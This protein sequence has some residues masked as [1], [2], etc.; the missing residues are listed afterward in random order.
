MILF[1]NIGFLKFCIG[2][3]ME[4]NSFTKYGSTLSI[5]NHAIKLN[6]DAFFFVALKTKTKH[7]S[8]FWQ[9]LCFLFAMC[10]WNIM[11]KGHYLTF[12][13]IFLLF[14]LQISKE[15]RP[16]FSHFARPIDITSSAQLYFRLL[17]A[18]TLA[19][20]FSCVYA[21][22]QNSTDYV[23]FVPGIA[24]EFGEEIGGEQKKET[25]A[26]V[27]SHTEFTEVVLDCWIKNAEDF[28]CASS[29]PEG[30]KFFDFDS[31][32]AIKAFNA[33][34]NAVQKLFPPR[35]VAE[36][37][38]NM[39]GV[40]I[41]SGT[42]DT[43]GSKMIAAIN[44]IGK[45]IALCDPWLRKSDWFTAEEVNADAQQSFITGG[46][47]YRDDNIPIRHISIMDQFTVPQD[48]C[49]ESYF[50]INPA[51]LQETIDL[52]NFFKKNEEEGVPSSEWKRWCMDRKEAAEKLQKEIKE[53]ERNG[54]YTMAELIQFLVKHNELV[55]HILCCNE[56]YTSSSQMTPDAGGPAF[57]G[58]CKSDPHQIP[59][60][61]P[62]ISSKTQD[63]GFAKQVLQ[64]VSEVSTDNPV[65]LGHL[66]SEEYTTYVLYE[67]A[68]PMKSAD[69][70]YSF[71]G[72][73]QFVRDGDHMISL[74]DFRKLSKP[75]G[76][77]KGEEWEEVIANRRD[78]IRTADVVPDSVKFVR[79]LH[80]EAIS[81]SR[82]SIHLVQ[83]PT[84]VL[85]TRNSK[86]TSKTS[87][88]DAATPSTSGTSVVA[89]TSDETFK[90]PRTPR[91]IGVS[92]SGMTDVKFSF[93]TR[94]KSPSNVY[95][96]DIG[97]M[98]EAEKAKKTESAKKKN[99]PATGRK[100]NLSRQAEKS[101]KKT[102][103]QKTEECRE[104]E[105]GRFK[106]PRAS[107]MAR[108]RLP[109]VDPNSEK[110]RSKK[111]VPED[112]KSVENR[113]EK[114]M[115]EE[116]NS[117]DTRESENVS[118][119][120]TKEEDMSVETNPEGDMPEQDVP[121][122]DP[123]IL[124]GS[125][126]DNKL[127]MPKEDK[128]KVWNTLLD[129]KE[130][131]PYFYYPVGD[132][133]AMNIATRTPLAV[134]CGRSK[135]RPDK[136]L[137]WDKR[138]HDEKEK[139]RAEKGITRQEDHG[140]QEVLR[141]DDHDKIPRLA[142]VKDGRLKR[143][144]FCLQQAVDNTAGAWHAKMIRRELTNER[145][146]EEYGKAASLIP[147]PLQIQRIRRSFR[148]HFTY[149]PNFPQDLV[150][151]HHRLASQFSLGGTW[152]DH[153]IYLRDYCRAQ[154]KCKATEGQNPVRKPDT[155]SKPC[156]G[157]WNLI[158]DCPPKP[159]KAVAQGV[160][161]CVPPKN[162]IV[163]TKPAWWVRAN[164]KFLEPTDG[165]KIMDMEDGSWIIRATQISAQQKL[166][167]SDQQVK[168]LEAIFK[169]STEDIKSKI[170]SWKDDLEKIMT[171]DYDAYGRW[172]KMSKL[173]WL[174][175]NRDS[176]LQR[177]KTY[178]DVLGDTKGVMD[179]ENEPDGFLF[180]TTLLPSQ[181]Q[182]K[183]TEED[184]V[185]GALLTGK[186]L[187]PNVFQDCQL[188]ASTLVDVAPQKLNKGPAKE[189]FPHGTT[190][191][192]T[193]APGFLRAA[194][195]QHKTI[196]KDNT[197]FLDLTPV[198]LVLGTNYP[199]CG[200]LGVRHKHRP[201]DEQIKMDRDF[202]LKF[203]DHLGI[204]HPQDFEHFRKTPAINE[205]GK[206][207]MTDSTKKKSNTDDEPNAGP[208]DSRSAPGGPGSGHDSGS[209]SGTCQSTQH[210]GTTEPG[211]SDSGSGPWGSGSG[212]SQN[213][214]QGDTTESDKHGRRPE[215]S[216]QSED[217]EDPLS[218]DS[219]ESNLVGSSRKQSC[220]EVDA[221]NGHGAPTT[222]LS[223][224]SQNNSQTEIIP[225]PSLKDA[226]LEQR[227]ETDNGIVTADVPA[228]PLEKQ[229]KFRWTFVP[230]KEID[231][232]LDPDAPSETIFLSSFSIE[233]QIEQVLD[234]MPQ[235]L[236]EDKAYVE[237]W[238]D[239]V[240]VGDVMYDP[241]D[242]ACP[243]C[244]QK[245]WASFLFPVL[246]E[247]Y[248]NMERYH[249][250]NRKCFRIF[251]ILFTLQ[252]LTYELSQLQDKSPMDAARIRTK[253]INRLAIPMAIQPHEL[254][255]DTFQRIEVVMGL[256]DAE[257]VNEF[258]ETDTFR[259]IP[260]HLQSD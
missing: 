182:I 163:K 154:E 209:G 153:A 190:D 68:W 83:K 78:N 189:K 71:E 214:Q 191:V 202:S 159:A 65:I 42:Y 37:I 63:E 32:D 229:K 53:D 184:V 4:T 194:R 64:A 99:T 178:S 33:H 30:L 130:N 192:S 177:M 158:T 170:E 127:S 256:R 52:A 16:H 1:D 92:P 167:V 224:V 137:P 20:A 183:T 69:G 11:G 36:H 76:F 174:D 187:I 21:S 93:R 14:Y 218:N 155:E 45:M 205:N 186:L 197:L 115:P 47:S 227:Q 126:S 208:S 6:G 200:P 95:A 122:L 156:T 244:N 255:R 149:R 180:P 257:D 150:T 237:R 188:A 116:H 215:A 232:A 66:S 212:T 108:R 89:G 57:M 249:L 120:P 112:P 40:F 98:L 123:N 103:M 85:E 3:V 148:E 250:E 175:D 253:V 254:P 171:I 13:P 58:E 102:K 242:W 247:A 28:L 41:Q 206:K 15:V 43:S 75:K 164:N 236:D 104:V 135:L 260:R 51:M 27:L 31:E 77:E 39:V 26:K 196:K 161:A 81:T 121:E 19:D 166:F 118:K 35:R 59:A 84:K 125:E 226:P 142:F 198:P 139:Y 145:L 147:T 88:E 107:P 181:G 70:T 217:I 132:P 143:L 204:P 252:K 193:T 91:Q 119:E 44:A 195:D 34:I 110:N 74:D 157:E 72:T 251:C 111:D 101:S 106:T 55:L 29:F 207:K 233:K 73:K 152:L 243:G 211:P 231:R 96:P 56:K 179:K 100:R 259:S 140:F 97:N 151:L 61:T 38:A 138:T 9:H 22:S 201:T 172:A 25:R 248:R 67:T 235:A 86:S 48:Y 114:N 23:T 50:T 87:L 82:F 173:E 213:A 165:K 203:H 117:V 210:G 234:E 185:A 105:I 245:S 133:C 141:Y 46:A 225:S 17:F 49:E 124:R 136:Y 246:S 144:H 230:S 220:E 18:N 219:A 169:G 146:R 216:G 199:T 168:D 134:R 160:G 79:R 80:L 129:E 62:Q 90:T 176:F 241:P 162:P 8:V 240:D 113:S 12:M 228:C 10:A 223:N 128:L 94:P 239:H 2:V 60:F 221:P 222:V 5:E 258:I 7:A 131:G 109:A 54:R 24:Q 238:K